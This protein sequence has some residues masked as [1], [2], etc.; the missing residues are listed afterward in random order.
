M[1][2]YLIY[3]LDDHAEVLRQYLANENTDKTILAGL[4]KRLML[5][6]FQKKYMDYVLNKVNITSMA[7]FEIQLAEKLGD[8]L[9]HD[10]IAAI[11]KHLSKK[12]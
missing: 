8:E 6:L 5:K 2:A 4:I 9:S 3:K 7:D 1:N 11:K 10:I 12:K